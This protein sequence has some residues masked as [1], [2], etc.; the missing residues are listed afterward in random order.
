LREI[1]QT[2]QV[3]VADAVKLD[4]YQGEL[5]HGLVSSNNMVEIPQWRHA[6]V[7]FPHPLLQQGLVILDTPGLN[8]L[9]SEPELTLSTLPNAQVVLFVLAADT[10]V[11]RSDMEMWQHHIKSFYSNQRGLVIVL[12]KIDTLWDELK[13]PHE[14]KGV[15]ARQ[16]AATART[17]G[18]SE[19]LIFPISAQKAL[20]AK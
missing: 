4:L 8:A 3:S 14:I 11:T 1:I 7:S 2:K 18:I 6:I 10:G 9:G 17:L 19:D 5:H 15:I 13:F 12:N 20:V 16:R